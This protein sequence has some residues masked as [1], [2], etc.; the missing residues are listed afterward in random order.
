M[1]VEAALERGVAERDRGAEDPRLSPWRADHAGSRLRPSTTSTI[2][3]TQRELERLI[4]VRREATGSKAALPLEEQLRGCAHVFVVSPA[5]HDTESDAFLWF[6]HHVSGRSAVASCQ[7]HPWVGHGD[8]EHW[9][10]ILEAFEARGPRV[11]VPG[12]GPVGGLRPILAPLRR[13]RR[14]IRLAARP[15]GRAV[16]A[17]RLEVATRPTR[18]AQHTRKRARQWT[19][20]LV[21]PASRPSPSSSTARRRST[22]WR[23]WPPKQRATARSCSSSRRRSFPPTRRRSGRAPWPA[24]RCPGATRRS[25]CSHASRWRCPARPRRRIGETA[26]RHGVW[27]VTGVNEIDPARPRRSTTR[28]STTPP[29]GR[30]R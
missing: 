6:E 13:Y 21:S 9:I 14:S 26:K 2:V 23:L 30:S 11:V 8:L 28:C 15:T 25:R 10:E 19:S 12:H 27:I 16:W 29:T 4:R 18:A 7:N 24:G 20:R 3:S 5:G 17:F 1:L 22:S